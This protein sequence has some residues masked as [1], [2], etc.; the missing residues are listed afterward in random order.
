MIKALND[1]IKMLK[2][3]CNELE[4]HFFDDEWDLC[5][6]HKDELWR[7]TGIQEHDWDDS[8]LAHYIDGMQ[9]VIHLFE[10]DNF[11]KKT[12]ETEVKD[13]KRS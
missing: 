10:V 6:F 8:N 11:T 2:D 12:S 4:E 5:D 3:I 1:D 7:I 13:E 9:R